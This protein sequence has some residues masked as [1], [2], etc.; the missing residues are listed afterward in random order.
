[1]VGI[2]MMNRLVPSSFMPQEDQGYFTVELELPEGAT[3]E[4]TREVARAG[5]GFP[6]GGTGRTVRAER[7]G[8]QGAG[9]R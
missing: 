9:A 1:M 4:R 2:W 7:H 3:V 8:F 5:H 6:D